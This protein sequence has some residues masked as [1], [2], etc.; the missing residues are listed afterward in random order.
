M[1]L[2]RSKNILYVQVIQ[3]KIPYIQIFTKDKRAIKKL[4]IK[5]A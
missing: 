3:K 1:I 5:T 2:N 4:K